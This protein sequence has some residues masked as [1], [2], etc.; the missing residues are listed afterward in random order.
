MQK[1]AVNIRPAT[2]PPDPKSLHSSLEISAAMPFGRLC[3]YTRETFSRLL[4]YLPPTSPP[5]ETPSKIAQYERSGVVSCHLGVADQL[6]SLPPGIDSS[7]MINIGTRP[8]CLVENVQR[9]RPFL[10]DRCG[11]FGPENLKIVGS[12][13]FDAGGFADLWMGERNDGAIVAIKSL[14]CY[15]SL[16]C[17]PAYVVSDERSHNPFPLI[18]IISRSCTR[19]HRHTVSS[20]TMT[21]LL[22][23]SLGFIQPLNTPSLSFLSL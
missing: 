15:S 1:Q 4:M 12:Y 11:F 20:T 6:Q 2:I 22:S 23:H 10:P 21:T 19:K 5:R 3:F 13:P 17:L 14:R 9:F 16:S 18:N 7:A 8:E